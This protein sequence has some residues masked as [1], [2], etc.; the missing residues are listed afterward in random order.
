M[1][2]NYALMTTTMNNSTKSKVKWGG[3]TDGTDKRHCV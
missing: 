2:K 1:K 3:A